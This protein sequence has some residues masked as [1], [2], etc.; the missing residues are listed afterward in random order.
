MEVVLG[1]IALLAITTAVTIGLVLWLY[2][3]SL[4]Q[5]RKK[6]GLATRAVA[7]VFA[8]IFLIN[9]VNNSSDLLDHLDLV[10]TWL[11]VIAVGLVAGWLIRRRPDLS[12][13]IIVLAMAL[14]GG[15]VVVGSAIYSRPDLEPRPSLDVGSDVESGR[16]EHGNPGYAI[17]FS[18]E[19]MVQEVSAAAED[20]EALTKSFAK[21]QTLDLFA[22]RKDGAGLC[23][24]LRVKPSPETEP[25]LLGVYADAL[26]QSL[27]QHEERTELRRER[28]DLPAGPAWHI[29]Y[30]DGDD[31]MSW[32]VL[33]G[34]DA[35]HVLMCWDD[36]PPDDRWRSIAETFEL[37]SGS[38]TGS[39]S[40]VLAGG[41]VE[42]PEDGFAVTFPDG[43]T[44]EEVA[45]S[46][47]EWF[48]GADEAQAL[49]TVIL[50]ASDDGSDAE[51]MVV[52]YASLASADPPWPSVDVATTW[53]LDRMADDP[54]YREPARTYETLPSGRTGHITATDSDGW[55]G[56]AYYFR[57]AQG[58]AWMHLACWSPERPDD[59]W[60]SIAETFEFL[61]AEE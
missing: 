17:E 43:W 28:V 14:A 54:G 56:D 12:R 51:C 53:Y 18:D 38:G 5:E 50:W 42:R 40:P 20:T 60:L 35:I 61:P 32:Y 1:F 45:P 59:H 39:A 34:R 52:D 58:D 7:G 36:Q 19:W 24:V 10:A 15:I 16:I 29:D 2:K 30:E 48:D 44:V 25:M 11:S 46:T 6:A 13:A 41:R 26:G 57:D 37:L 9:F 8:V 27:A 23:S 22:E 33:R 55:S 21:D 4:G 31:I 47:D 3:R 49:E